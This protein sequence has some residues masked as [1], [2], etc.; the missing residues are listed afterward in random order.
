MTFKANKK[1]QSHLVNPWTGPDPFVMPCLS[2]PLS[3]TSHHCEAVRS[4]SISTMVEELVKIAFAI[5]KAWQKLWH[6]EC[7]QLKSVDWT[8]EQLP[9]LFA[10]EESETHKEESNSQWREKRTQDS[11]IPSKRSPAC[12]WSYRLGAL[13]K[14][15]DCLSTQSTCLASWT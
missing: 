6:L 4:V 3:I 8:N 5:L 14:L 2:T 13:Y 1:F 15:M 7:A 11:W 9:L 12:N 10:V